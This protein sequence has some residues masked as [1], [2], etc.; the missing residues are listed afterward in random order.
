MSK[1]KKA[2]TIEEGEVFDL[3]TDPAAWEAYEPQQTIIIEL[4][5]I[6]GV[7]GLRGLATRLGGTQF[8]GCLSFRRRYCIHTSVDPHLQQEETMAALLFTSRLQSRGLRRAC[9]ESQPLRTREL[10]LQALGPCRWTCPSTTSSRTQQK[11]KRRSSR[12]RRVGGRG[13]SPWGASDAHWAGYPRDT[14][15]PSVA[16][17]VGGA[18]RS[19]DRAQRDRRGGE[20]GRSAR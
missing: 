6:F 8:E 12:W 18:R 11:G 4:T 14:P 17:R 20:R 16:W 3:A 2:A 13:W 10:P 7:E 15:C 9:H 19:L 1:R 5:E